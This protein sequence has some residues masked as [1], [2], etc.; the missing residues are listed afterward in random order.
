M[1]ALDW[2]Q[3]PFV[4]SIPGKVGGLRV[5]CQPQLVPRW[6]AS[7]RNS[8]GL[9]PTSRTWGTR[10]WPTAWVLAAAIGS[11]VSSDGPGD[12]G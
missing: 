11:S 7:P 4:E 10:H 5:A 1:S 12:A 3:C 9:G 8:D 2:S 6:K